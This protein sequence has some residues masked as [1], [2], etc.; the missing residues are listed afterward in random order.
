MVFR[1]SFLRYVFNVLMVVSFFAGRPL[2]GS[3]T[4]NNIYLAQNPVGAANG[5]D[6]ADALA[7]SWFNNSANWGSGSNQIGPGTTVHVC[8]AITGA[9]GSSALTVLGSG[10]SDN[11]I[12]IQFEP[13]S[14]M[15]APYWGGASGACNLGDLCSGAIT[16]NGYNNVVIDGGNSGIIQ[17]TANG[18]GQANGHSSAGIFLNGS[19][20]TVQNL[21]I[22]NIYLNQG[23]SAG[24]T[25]SNGLDTADIR[26]D[27]GS[28][29]I[30]VNNNTLNDARA[31]IWADTS[32]SNVNFYGN[33]ITDHAWHISLSGSGAPNVYN[34]Q[35]TD[36]TNW[37]FPSDAY[38]TDGIIVYGDTSVIT[39][40]IYSNYIYGDLGAGSPTGFIFCTYGAQ[41]SGS[42][43]GCTIFNNLLVGTGYSATND[44]GIY[45]HSGNGTNPMGPHYIY[46]NTFVG[47]LYQIYAETD[48]GIHYTIENN[49]FVGNGAQW[50]I[51]GNNSPL[52]D[53]TCDYN[54]YF[55]GR[56]F[57]PFSW[58][59]V[60]NGQFADWQGAFEDPSGAS[61]NPNLDAT[62]HLS[63]GSPAATMGAN[64][65]P[66][67][68][69]A[70]M[71]GQ[72]SV[73]GVNATNDGV[74][75]L[76]SAWNWPAGA[77][78][79]GTM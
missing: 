69:S 77:F 7:T 20:L 23:S 4:G 67:G 51:Q 46:N 58:G 33:T 11:P 21:S 2:L 40:S 48:P 32:G 27:G 37:Q 61:T 3:S 12:T 34:N 44:Q 78:G 17:N 29:N 5:A 73:V 65:S 63:P 31:G 56:G 41:G 75:R 62:Y 66:V 72:P 15:S 16:V 30:Q 14:S 9:A 25:D 49:V 42:G 6:C 43:S 59:P 13:G 1:S 26:I 55:G 76:P 64:L 57:G 22:K 8:G 19:N 39:P 38:H 79:T 18:T 60:S 47:L 74:P 54:I 52:S 10:A 24:A 53:L 35:I 71:V 36:W 68:I 50:Y 28:S 45:F 70:L